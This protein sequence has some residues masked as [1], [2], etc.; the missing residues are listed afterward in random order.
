M[1]CHFPGDRSMQHSAVSFHFFREFYKLLSLVKFIKVFNNLDPKLQYWCYSHLS[2]V[3]NFGQVLSMLINLSKNLS[4][5]F[6]NSL[7][8]WFGNYVKSAVILNDISIT[9]IIHHRQI[10]ILSIVIMVMVMMVISWVAPSSPIRCDKGRLH[11]PLLTVDRE[12]DWGGLEGEGWG[13]PTGRVTG[14]S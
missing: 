11:A 4:K 2:F 9:S 13:I 3:I 14:G 12:G 7:G 6:L 5:C 8:S 1:K 10:A